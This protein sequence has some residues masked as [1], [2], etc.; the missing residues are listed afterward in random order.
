M[1]LKVE[2][3]TKEYVTRFGGR[4]VAALRGVDFGVGQGEFVE[5]GRASCRERV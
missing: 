2:G 3:L 1:L 4:R 5:I